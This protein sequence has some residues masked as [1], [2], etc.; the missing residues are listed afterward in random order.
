MSKILANPITT[1]SGILGLLTVLW[2]AYQTKSI[3]WIDLQA[4]LVSIGLIGAKDFNVT[5]GTKPQ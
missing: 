5:G 1:I 4:A 2:N 3:N